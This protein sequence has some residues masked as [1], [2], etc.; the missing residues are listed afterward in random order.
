MSRLIQVTVAVVVDSKQKDRRKEN[1][2]L[3]AAAAR[4]VKLLYAE[5]FAD[6]HYQPIAYPMLSDYSIIE[7]RPSSE[8]EWLKK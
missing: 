7:L 3:Q 5:I 1:L 4:A 8:I 6:E 2:T